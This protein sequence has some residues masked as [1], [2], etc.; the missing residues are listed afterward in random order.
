MD[1]KTF[2]T[3]MRA[4]GRATTRRSTIPALGATLLG[5]GLGHPA[6]MAK[7]KR[8]RRK[9]RKDK[10]KSPGGLPIDKA[11]C[12]AYDCSGSAP[13]QLCI[14]GWPALFVCPDSYQGCNF[15]KSESIPTCHANCG[16]Y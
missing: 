9:K 5:L 11:T 3:L 6:A 4:V 10:D 8:K 15:R 2:A 1:S 16:Y 12:C 13:R 7:N 14:E